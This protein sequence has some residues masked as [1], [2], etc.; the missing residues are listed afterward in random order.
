MPRRG[1]AGSGT[2]AAPGL[3]ATNPSAGGPLSPS[4]GAADNFAALGDDNTAIPPDT[5]GAVGPNHLMTTLNTQVRIQNRSGG[6]ISTVS[7]DGF[8]AGLSAPL[9]FDP[10][11]LYDRYAGRW[12][13]TAMANPQSAN[14]GVMVAVSGTNDPTGSWL[15]YGIDADGANQ[16]W[17]DYPSFGFN[18]DWIVVQANMF[19]IAGNDWVGSNIYVFRKVKLFAASTSNHFRLFN[20]AEGFAQ[21]PSVTYDPAHAT[22]YMVEDWNGQADIDPAPGTQLGGVLRMAK[23]SGAVFSETYT[24]DIFI[25]DPNEWDDGLNNPPEFAPQAGSTRN[26]DAGDARMQNCMYRNGSIWCVHGISLPADGNDLTPT[27][28][29]S[30]QWWQISTGGGVLQRGRIDDGDGIAPLEFYAFPSIAVNANNDVLIGYSK[31]SEDIFASAAYSFRSAIDPANTLRDPVVYKSGLAAY[32]KDCGGPVNRWG[33]FSNAVVDP[34]NDADLWT[35]QEYA[36]ITGT[37][38]TCPEGD[39]WGTWWAHVASAAIAAPPS[40]TGAATA[41]FTGDVT[42][43]DGDNITFADVTGGGNTPVAGTVVCRNIAGVAVDCTG[44]G[45]R[46]AVFTPAAPLTAG[47]FYRFTV[48]PDSLLEADKIKLGSTPVAIAAKTVRPAAEEETSIAVTPKWRTVFTSG[49]LGGSYTTAHLRGGSAAFTFSG[50]AKIVWITIAGPNQGT[51]NVF[52]DNVF[53][54]T[55]NQYL[56]TTRYGITRTFS[57]STAQHTIK[58]IVNGNKGSSSGTDT[59]VTVD[60]FRMIPPGGG[61]G[62]LFSTPTVRYTWRSGAS[63]LAS[64]G[65][66]AI[67]NLP[68]AAYEFVAYGTG[69]DIY[70]VTGPAH[71]KITIYDGSTIVLTVDT[72]GSTTKFGVKR[73]VR[74]RALGL[75]RWRMVISGSKNGA[76]TGTNIL[77]DRFVAV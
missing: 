44:A 64:G 66:Y 6:V 38:G 75:H 27:E 69:I 31:F 4:P 34:V 36:E 63:T 25:A 39:R 23:I 54:G 77:L 14:S 24:K 26:I 28:R 59:H 19:E 55:F 18:K 8:W 76:S 16:L 10:K 74:N 47:K 61:N 30:I 29:T 52:V 72:Y 43:V 2:A 49:A 71:G 15:L 33:D 67:D 3:A 45:V 60:A 48:N 68:N 22:I 5:M 62:T 20:D 65:R 46:V 70:F 12:Y 50:A 56:S 9:A 73:S 13:F 1:A 40:V 37:G 7:L 17:T 41:T 51:A 35:I 57:V 53:R 11:V 32:D 42:G 21:A 58:I